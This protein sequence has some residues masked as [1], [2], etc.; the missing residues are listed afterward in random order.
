MLTITLRRSQ[1]RRATHEANDSESAVQAAIATKSPA[2]I[3]ADEAFR[4]VA[5]GG[6][7]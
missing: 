4:L 7:A 6:C 1:R 5:D 3:P 2:T